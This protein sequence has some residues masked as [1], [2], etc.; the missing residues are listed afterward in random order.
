MGV[1]D[2]IEDIVWDA[3][4][5]ALIA[6]GHAVLE[7]AKRNIP[8]GDPTEDPSAHITLSDSGTV[9]AHADRYGDVRV[10]FDT[11]YAAKQE[12]DINLQHPRGGG[13]H[14]L[15]RALTEVIPT[16]PAIVA[17]RIDAATATGRISDPGRSHR[18]R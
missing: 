18:R 6:A 13:P 4:H 17:S 9:E 10:M 3:G 1:G 14:Y 5:A 2:E 8:V 11:A 7:A 15:Q 16:L 12:F